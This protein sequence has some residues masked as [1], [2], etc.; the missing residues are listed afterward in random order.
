M[1]KCKTN[2]IQVDVGPGGKR[3]YDP[4]TRQFC[5]GPAGSAPRQKQSATL[6]AEGVSGSIAKVSSKSNLLCSKGQC[7]TPS[8]ILQLIRK[9]VRTLQDEPNAIVGPNEVRTILLNRPEIKTPG[10]K[11]KALSF[12]EAISGLEALG[13]KVD[14]ASIIVR[15]SG[16]KGRAGSLVKSLGGLS[17]PVPKLEEVK[18]ESISFGSFVPTKLDTVKIKIFILRG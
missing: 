6:D 2:A 10:G 15:P 7:F 16:L 1:P 17:A 12:G 3:W 14:V 18:A 5:K 9:Q 13:S 8:Q 11:D 4:E